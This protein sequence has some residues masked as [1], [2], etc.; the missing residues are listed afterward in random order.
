MKILPVPE[1]KKLDQRTISEESIA[2][3]DLMERAASRFTDWVLNQYPGEEGFHIFCGTGNNGGDGLVSAR[4]LSR[5]GKEVTV[6]IVR[7]SDYESPDF[8]AN[9]RRLNELDPSIAHPWWPGNPFPE[10][11]PDHVLIDAIWGSGLSRP[12]SGPPAE[13]I[14]HLNN[15]GARI[16]ALDMPSGLFAD[17]PTTGAYIKATH[18]VSFQVPKLAFF[19]PEHYDAAGQWHI[20]DIGLLPEALE[21]A[22]CRYFYTLAEDL[23]PFIKPRAPFS[24]KGIFGH[25]LVVGGSYGKTGAIH[26]A[27]KAALRSGAGLVTAWVPSCAYSP[28]Q[29]GVPEMMVIT[30]PGD[31]FLTGFPENPEQWNAIGIGPGMGQEPA[32]AIAFGPWL[33]RLNQPVVLDAD[34]LNLLAKNPE[35]L[36]YLPENSILTPHPGEFKRLNEPWENG[37]E[38]LEK[39][40]N[41]AQR[42][43]IILVLKGAYTAVCLPGGTCHLNSTG[44]P[45][46][47]TAGS[48]DALTGVITSLLGQGF[49]PELAAKIGVFVHGLAGDLAAEKLGETGLIASD[50]IAHLPEAFKLLNHA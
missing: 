3:I 35:W 33:K 24:H 23:E 44:N 7:L 6:H 36:E 31:N 38:K 26:L 40:L 37:F 47:A 27:G 28:L 10:I 45:G 22:P 5:A 11:N 14:N 42:H 48:G 17:Q 49:T 43:R 16:I 19:V 8:S 21:E 15:S 34:A 9:L 30:G 1:I 46:M 50:I 4:L 12:V 32:T 25:S 18:T 29:T 13:L 41:F 20:V 2:S 39:A